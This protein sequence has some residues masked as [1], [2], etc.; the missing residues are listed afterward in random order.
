MSIGKKIGIGFLTVIVVFVISLILIIKEINN[1]NTK[2]E[3]AVDEQVTQ[4]QLANDIKFGMAMQGL[5]VRAIMIDDTRNTRQL[6]YIFKI[7]R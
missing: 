5:Y 7:L 6:L 1:I 4:V 2:V 3:K